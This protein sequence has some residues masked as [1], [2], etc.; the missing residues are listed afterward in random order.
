MGSL[1]RRLLT[2]FAGVFIP[3]VAVA[4]TVSLLSGPIEPS[5][6]L[7]TLNS[8]INSNNAAYGTDG[9]NLSNA[10]NTPS[11]TS[12]VNAVSITAGATTVAPKISVGD[13]G[14]GTS[15]TNIGLVVSGK[16][17]GNLCL[18]GTTCANSSLQAVNTAS[19]VTHV[20]V[21]G[22]TTGVAPSIAA[23]GETNLDLSL[24]GA[25]TGHVTLGATTTCSGTTTATCS[26]QRFV[27]SITGLTTAAAGNTSA[28]M[29]VT[30]TRVV[31]ASVNVICS[32]N[33]Y[34]GTGV[35]IVTN[36][37]PGTGSVSMTVTNI[38]ASG[39][40]NATVPIACLVI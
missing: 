8:L 26:A 31:S 20:T 21:T 32:V 19:A 12:A 7:A 23:A 29:T 37:T 22:Q 5:Q 14:T 10:I 13:T 27:V 3:V 16:G 18:A 1:F 33:G 38:A 2:A 15:D 17:T 30:N 34:S 28:A 39:S 11:V 24:L 35:P 40:L 4:G 36:I 9:A 6:T 25:G